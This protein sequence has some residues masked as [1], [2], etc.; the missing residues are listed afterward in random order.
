M[1]QRQL[2][3]PFWFPAVLLFVYPV[4]WF[5]VS[6]LPT[7]EHSEVV[8]FG[9]TLDLIVVVP[10]AYILLL[11]RGRGWPLLSIIPVFLLSFLA[12]RLLVPGEYHGTLDGVGYGLPVLELGA[13]G[14]LIYR[15]TRIAEM[16][17]ATA[18]G[19]R[20]FH[21]SLRD[22]LEKDLPAP[23]ARVMAFEAA[24]FRYALLPSRPP[25]GETLRYAEKSGYGAVLAGILMAM[26]VELVGIHFLLI[27]WGVLAALI[28]A[29]LSIYGFLW[30]LGDFRAMRARPHQIVPGGLILRCGLRWQVEVPFDQIARISR[31]RKPR[32]PDHFL[33]LAPI[34]DP[35]V[36]IEFRSPLEA[37]GPYGLRRPA[38]SVGILVDDVA[39]LKEVVEPH[40]LEFDA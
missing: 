38:H 29:A 37:T 35:R 15:G 5:V 14:Y 16:V 21:D 6:A 39:A 32:S 22:A 17:A 26:L 7:I 24:L 19:S 18:T 34:G 23:L 30:L 36:I 1:N 13:I 10:A 33:N 25:P 20:D 31:S 12:A 11:V 8:A 4:A 2:T 3:S 9:L 27:Q 40:G 28:H